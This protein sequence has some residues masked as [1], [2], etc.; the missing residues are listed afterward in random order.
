MSQIIRIKFS[1]DLF[2]VP[3]Q[4]EIN[5]NY[6]LIVDRS[7]ARFSPAL[8]SCGDNK[9]IPGERRK[10]RHAPEGFSFSENV[11]TQF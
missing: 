11:S 6:D 7:V 1:G 2:L 4:L 5:L 9:V 8:T 10:H 3:E